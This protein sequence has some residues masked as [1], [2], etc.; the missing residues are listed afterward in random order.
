MHIWSYCVDFI[1]SLNTG[2]TVLAVGP[3]G[4]GAYMELLGNFVLYGCLIQV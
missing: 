3:K 4:S 1:W 2:L